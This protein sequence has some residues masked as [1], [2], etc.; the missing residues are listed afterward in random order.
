L[1]DGAVVHLGDELVDGRVRMR[2]RGRAHQARR[3]RDV[4]VCEP[5]RRV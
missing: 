3:S 2:I 4:D 1:T 5:E